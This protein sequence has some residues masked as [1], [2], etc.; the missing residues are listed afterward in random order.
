MIEAESIK[1]RGL[2]QRGT[3][4]LYDLWEKWK[5]FSYEL[6]IFCLQQQIG[7]PLLPRKS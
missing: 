6:F 1:F 2:F 3:T 4:L 7:P 5:C